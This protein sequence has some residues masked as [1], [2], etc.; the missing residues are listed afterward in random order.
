M[1]LQSLNQLYERLAG[2]D[3]YNLPQPG[4]SSQNVT[5]CIVLNPDGT[6]QDIQDA[7]KTLT[8]TTK[9]GKTKSRQVPRQLLLPGDSKPPGQGI[10]PCT[11]W[12]N[13]AYLLGYKKPD[14]N[15]EKAAK[16]TARALETFAVSRRHHLAL[17]STINDPAFSIVCRFLESWNPAM[18]ADW[19]EKLDDFASTGFGV[20]RVL[21]G[22]NYVHDLPAVKDWWATQQ[23]TSPAAGEVTAPCLITGENRPIARLHDPAIK[24]VN[25]AA[26]G[27]A[28]LASFNLKAFESYAKD[29]SYNAPVSQKAAFQYCNAL[30]ALLSGPRSHRHRITIGDATT[31]FWTERETVTESLFAAFFTGQTK[32]APETAE[33]TTTEDSTLDQRLDAFLNLLR[34]GTATS[35]KDLGDDPAT[36]FYILGLS[37]NVTR[38]SVRFWHVGTL[39]EMIERLHEHFDCI[40]LQRSFDNEPEFPAAI[41]L[42][43]QTAPFRNG[44]FE[45]KAISPLL[46]GQ[47][48]QA[49]LHG[50]PYPMTLIQGVLNRLRANDPVNYLKAS[51]L[52]A[53]LTRNFNQTITMS[54]DPENTKPAYLL[55]RLFAALEKTQQDALGNVNAGLRERFYSSAS[56][57]PASVFPRI[58]RTYQHHLA[59]LQGGLRVNRERL[60]QAIHAPLD[61]NTGYPTHLNLEDQGLFAI[62]Y[63]HQRQD[64]FT[65][66]STEQSTT[67]KN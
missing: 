19:A 34:R 40:A 23:G 63:Y 28:K 16:D 54:L 48:M 21:P 4:I 31:V 65:S 17:E 64:L 61:P 43:D 18:A 3:D 45:R 2:E 6:L 26:P 38:L 57:T 32:E 56:A 36:K 13:T 20:F 27:G 35:F 37:G 14:K 1:I 7:R 24:G 30:N 51:I 58:L 11:L 15:P 10:N 49:I 42:L 50:T 60:V 39:R 25:G 53:T 46:G 55:G 8:E 44:K 9:A 47:L 5:F 12:D 41:R 33:P 59:K 29:Q 66:K 67:S 52:K 22:R 62:G